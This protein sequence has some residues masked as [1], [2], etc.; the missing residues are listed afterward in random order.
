VASVPRQTI[1]CNQDPSTCQRRR[2]CVDGGIDAARSFA[3]LD[4]EE[5]AQLLHGAADPGSAFPPAS[6]DLARVRQAQQ[7]PLGR[8]ASVA[9]DAFERPVLN[10]PGGDT[11]VRLFDVGAMF[12]CLWLLASMI[13]D[14]LTPKELTVYMIGAAIAPFV[15]I[16]AVLHWRRV[17]GFDFA[18]ALGALWMTAGI[19]LE[20]ITPKSLSPFAVVIALAP[21]IVVGVVINFQRWSRSR[22][23]PGSIPSSS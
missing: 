6:S 1:A 11:A 10:C 15:V 7:A 22:S 23:R 19:V 9:I 14:V 12:G 3:W 18:I 20:L 16:L 2:V 17:P 21:L 13:I 8:E 5:L 4:N